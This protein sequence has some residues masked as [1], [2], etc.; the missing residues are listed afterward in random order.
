MCLSIK[1]LLT[2]CRLN[3]ET[4]TPSMYCLDNAQTHFKT[5]FTVHFI[6]FIKKQLSQSSP[7]TPNIAQINLCTRG[8]VLSSG[9]SIC[10]ILVSLL[11]SVRTR[12]YSDFAPIEETLNSALVGLYY[13]TIQLRANPTKT[14]VSLFHLR[15]H[16]CGKQLNISWNGVNLIH[17]NLPVYLGVK[18]D[19]TL[20]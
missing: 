14:Q 10:I 17:S 15:N 16:E 13:T 19:R 1:Y 6:N 20:S 8:R 2:R 11:I 12:T 7:S 9:R 18:L 3:H 4:R 5:N